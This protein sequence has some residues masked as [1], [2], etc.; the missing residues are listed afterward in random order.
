[1]AYEHDEQVMLNWDMYVFYSLH[2][3]KQSRPSIKANM[4]KPSVFR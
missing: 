2:N 1:M 4:T 3:N